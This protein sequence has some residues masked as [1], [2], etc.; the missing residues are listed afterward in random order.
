MRLLYLNHNYRYMATYNRAMQMAEAMARRGHQVTVMTVSRAYRWK[1]TWSTV[2]GVHLA[3][4]PNLGQD[5][6]GEGYGPLDNLLRCTHALFNKYDIIHM[7]DHKPNASFA[8]YLT[9]RLRGARLVADWADWWGGPGGINDV[10]TR[11]VPAVGK[12]EEWWELESKLRADGVV[13]IST[14]LHQRALDIGCPRE[15]VIQIPNGA[16][17]SL[18]RC[19]PVSEARTQLGVPQERPIIGFLGM[20]QGDM[21][22]VMGALEQLGNVWLMVVGPKNARVLEQARSFG[23]EDRLWQTDFVPEEKLGLY[24]ACADVMCLPLADRAAPIAAGFQ[25]NSCTTWQPDAPQS[26]APLEITKRLL[27]LFRLG[28]LLPLMLCSYG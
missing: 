10:P 19:Y 2:N 3:E 26:S 5:N 16:E 13:T 27:T 22:I 11:R 4:M 24:L 1:V 12:F 9:G 21:E 15:R 8:G 20:S 14:V 28:S 23:I 25:A 7:F 17:T 18:I 6:S